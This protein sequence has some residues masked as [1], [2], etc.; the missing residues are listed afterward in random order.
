MPDR[1]WAY[2]TPKPHTLLPQE[3]RWR[4]AAQA[5]GLSD[6]VKLRL[7]WI[8]HYH[9][10]GKKNATA[11]ARHFGLARSKF[12]YWLT[13]FDETNLRQLEDQPSTPKNRRRWN[14][15]P[16]ILQRMLAL[17]NESKRCWGKHKL[18]ALYATRYGKR[19][20]SWQFQRMIRVFKL[21]RSRYRTPCQHNGA[22]KERISRVI[23]QAATWLFQLDTIVLHLFGQKRYILT[24]VEHTGKLGYAWVTSSHS[25]ATARAFLDRLQA[26]VERPITVILTDNGSEFQKYFAQACNEQRTTRYYSRPHTPTDNPECERFN[27]TLKEE[28]LSFGGW[29]TDIH[30]MNR[31]LTNWLIIYNSIRPH[32]TLKNLTPLAYSIAHGLLSKR[33][34]SGTVA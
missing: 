25:S 31:S 7:E 29:H 14:P 8:I 15:D 6:R 10:V 1:S 17:R 33:S 9:T 24:A 30:A 2:F 23:R 26:L 32:D 22:K 20:A 19:I 27:R 18:A 16:L 12:Y 4:S 5:L 21:Y 34:S 3:Q 13:R 11:T 28:W